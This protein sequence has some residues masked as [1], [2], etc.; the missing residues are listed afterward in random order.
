MTSCVLSCMKL[1]GGP[2]TEYPIDFYYLVRLE[3]DR[4]QKME[5]G[6]GTA[7]LVSI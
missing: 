3:P 6:A 7:M 1:H 5:F 2:P 4:G